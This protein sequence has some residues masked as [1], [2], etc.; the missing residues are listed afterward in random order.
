VLAHR[1]SRRPRSGCYP[2]HHDDLHHSCHNRSRGHDGGG[3]GACASTSNH[4]CGACVERDNRYH[5]HHHRCGGSGCWVN[6][7]AGT[8]AVTLGLNEPLSGKQVSL[9]APL[10]NFSAAQPGLAPGEP[11]AEYKCASGAEVIGQ[12]AVT[13]GVWT[14]LARQSGI[15]QRQVPVTLAWQ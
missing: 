14:V 9:A 7:V 13:A 5:D 8:K 15:A 11:A 10:R 12:P 4:G 2:N 3:H 1:A 6:H